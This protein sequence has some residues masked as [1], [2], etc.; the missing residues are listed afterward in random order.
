MNA[1]LRI[2]LVFL[3][4][5]APAACATKPA[6]KLPE[7]H[8]DADRVAVAGLSSGAYMATQVHLAWP[9]IFSGAALVAGGPWG[10][11][12]GDLKTALT[13][14]MGGKPLPDP[15]AL[16]AHAAKQS[17]SGVIGPLSGLAD[18]H[19]YVLHGQ[20]DGLVAA[21]V[22][23]AA[24]DFYRKLQASHP[25]SAG[26]K[27]VYDGKRDFAH[28]LPIAAKGDNCKASEAPY[29]G[30]CGFDA[31]GEIFTQLYGPPTEPVDTAATGSL[32]SFDQG[33]LLG[34]IDDAFLADTGY[35]YLPK[36]CAKGTACG[37]LVVFHGCQQNAAAVGDKFVKDAGF[38]RWADLYNVAVLYPQTRATYAPLNPKAC[39]DWWG[40][41]G[42]D[43]DT[44]SGVQQQWLI[45][46]LAALGVPVPTAASGKH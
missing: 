44:R 5:L 31:A 42:A 2:L 41:S 18:D 33:A 4:A 39:W 26:L 38:N 46:A 16:A 37:V 28:N 7:I 21:T 14:C 17:S 9:E 30:Q 32:Q 43:Y 36:V 19:V 6:D 40:Y 3:L 20:A 1:S 34:D 23:E 10:C 35:A 29:L 13:S 11:A 22:S 27:V 12:K 15:E 24:A 8:V 25:E 45:H